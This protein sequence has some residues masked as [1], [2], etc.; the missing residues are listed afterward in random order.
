MLKL[1]W[2]SVKHRFALHVQDLAGDGVD[3]VF[4]L[5]GVI[6]EAHV[7]IL[8]PV[9]VFVVALQPGDLGGG[10]PGVIQGAALPPMV[11]AV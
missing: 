11:P 6:Y 4:V 3:G 9:L 1:S 2:R 10:E 7:V 8:E 5:H